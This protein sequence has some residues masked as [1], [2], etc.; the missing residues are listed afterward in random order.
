MRAAAANNAT[1]SAFQ[2]STLVLLLF[3]PREDEDGFEGS[4]MVPTIA[5]LNKNQKQ[6]EQE[7]HQKG[8]G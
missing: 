8:N 2:V 4:M 1:V 7:Y 3:A 6:R 5:A